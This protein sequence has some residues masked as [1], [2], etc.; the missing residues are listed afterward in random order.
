MT[1]LRKSEQSAARQTWVR[2]G[3]EVGG[4][5]GLLKGEINGG[6]TSVEP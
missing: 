3:T 2:E 5:L 4:N 6:Q 1:W